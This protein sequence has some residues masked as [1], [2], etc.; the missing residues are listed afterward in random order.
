[1]KKTFICLIVLCIPTLLMAQEQQVTVAE[2]TSAA[3][4]RIK[5]QTAA[6]EVDVTDISWIENENKDVLLYEIE[7]TQGL[8]L[9]LSGSKACRPILAVHSSEEGLYLRKYKELP[10]GI[11]FFIDWYK[12]QVDSCFANK[13][14]SLYHN[15]DWESL[16]GGQ[17]PHSPKSSGV[18]PLLKS[19]WMQRLPNNDTNVDAYNY[20]I[21][22]N[23][24][25]AHCLAGCVAVAMGQVMYY[26]KYPVLDKSRETQFDWCKMTDNLFTYSPNYYENRNAISYL[27]SECGQSVNMNYG[28]NS[29]GASSSDAATALKYEFEYHD[30][31]SYKIKITYSEED[32]IKMIKKDLNK[33]WPVIYG[34]YTTILANK[35]HTFICDGYNAYNEFHFNWGWDQSFN[36]PSDYY[37][38]NNLTPNGSNYHFYQDA[39]FGIRPAENQNWCNIT[40]YLE[41]F[42]WVHEFHSHPIYISTP[43]TMTKLVSAFSPLHASW[44]TIPN[45]ATATY[46]AHEEVHL[47]DGFTVE[48]GADFTA[49]IVP[50]PNCDNRETE[51]PETTDTSDNAAPPETASGHP[52]PATDYQPTTTD[53]YP[54]PTDGEVTVGVDG[55]V[56]SI[57]IYNMM[58]RPVGGWNIRSLASDQIVLDVSPLPA[59]TYILHIQT[60][61]GTT[62]KR[63]VVTR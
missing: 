36:D 46:Q 1:M 53:L 13:N 28:C 42:Y 40:L 29:S 54:N 30:D 8:T 63:L 3:V 38:L 27:L 58:G 26:W 60:P 24:N 32:W 21:S 31:L 35:G 19:N 18:S 6:T 44:Y 2:A 47:R 20:L 33:G 48:R 5:A 59:G 49:R 14:I 15:D 45:G 9:L 55:E 52:L 61:M 12:E 16:M 25:C 57:I 7:T 50:C 23:S 39:I 62:T 4:T 37:S 56:Q 22:G 34:G 11:K 10:C 51:S 17:M 43:K 41:D